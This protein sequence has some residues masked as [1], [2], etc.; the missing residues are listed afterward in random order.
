M[1]ILAYFSA[2]LER[3]VEILVLGLKD[4]ASIG[5]LKNVYLV[6]IVVNLLLQLVDDAHYISEGTMLP[7]TII[8]FD[9]SYKKDFDQRYEKE[10]LRN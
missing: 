3:L 2:I 8:D 10:L 1:N 5:R 6:L 4:V 9:Q 7:N